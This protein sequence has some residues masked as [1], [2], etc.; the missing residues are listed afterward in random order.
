M[1]YQPVEQINAKHLVPTE[2]RNDLKADNVRLER[3]Q[4]VAKPADPTGKAASGSGN[5]GKLANGQL[6][7]STDAAQSSQRLNGQPEVT[8]NSLKFNS[9]LHNHSSANYLDTSYQNDNSV[10]YT[11]VYKVNKHPNANHKS[12]I[13]PATQPTPN[14]QSNTLDCS[15]D[16]SIVP[17]ASSSSL[18]SRRSSLNSAHFTSDHVNTSGKQHKRTLK[19]KDDQLQSDS[20]RAS[21]RNHNASSNRHHSSNHHRKQRNFRPPESELSNYHLESS[22]ELQP[23]NQSKLSSVNQGELT[24]SQAGQANKPHRQHAAGGHGARVEQAGDPFDRNSSDCNNP[25]NTDDDSLPYFQTSSF[26]QDICNRLR[27]KLKYYFMNPIDKWKTKKKFP[28]K[29]LLQIIKI[30]FVTIHVLTYGSSMARFLNHQGNMAI[31]FRELLL[32]NWDPVRE[33]MAYPPSAGAYA[34]Y[35]IEDFYQNFDFAIKNFAKITKQATGSFGYLTNNTDEVSPIEVCFKSYVNGTMDPAQFEYNYNNQIKK[36]CYVL[37]SMG[38]AGSPNWEK[39]SFEKYLNDRAIALD[40][41]R[42]I[43]VGLRL[44]LRTIY[45]NNLELGAYPECYDVQIKINYDN[46]KH[47]GQLLIDLKT[48]SSVRDCKGNLI[49][50]VGVRL[51]KYEKVFLRILVVILCIMSFTLCTRSL[52]KSHKLGAETKAFFKQH[53]RRHLTLEDQME[54][55]DFWIIT[56]IVNDIFIIIGTILQQVHTVSSSS[57]DY[58]TC[59]MFLGIGIFLVWT[60]I[61]R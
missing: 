10:Y 22:N 11:P 55:Y 40:F 51:H 18:S 1:N 58:T 47:D 52:I 4:Q 33:V 35:T 45:L 36:K 38:P 56:I 23:P 31:S 3:R 29:L 41:N 17:V 60:G 20:K 48:K 27:W 54:F 53:F 7:D 12:L 8:A 9:Q 59:T 19:R 49:D 21:G 30:I 34:V 25:L 46:S 13:E 44:R 24:S 37:D 42:I 43:E 26:N 39:F 28:W 15:F 5:S 50:K 6:V 14:T 2:M 57:F 16:N 61:L 32:N